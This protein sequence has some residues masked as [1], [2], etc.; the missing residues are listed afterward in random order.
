M[1]LAALGETGV[2][3]RHAVMIGDSTYDMEMACSAGVKAIGVAWGYHAPALL[4]GA[5]AAHIAADYPA[6]AQMLR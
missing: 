4:R 6:L 3:P 2:D 1:V 5:G